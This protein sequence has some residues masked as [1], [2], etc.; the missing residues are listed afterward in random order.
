MEAG[1]TEVTETREVPSFLY[2]LSG[3]QLTTLDGMGKRGGRIDF[4]E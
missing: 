1:F 4:E 2:L 3:S